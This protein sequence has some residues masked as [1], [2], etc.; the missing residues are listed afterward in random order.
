[1]NAASAIFWQFC[2]GNFGGRTAARA[3]FGEINPSGRLSISI[4][5]HV[6]TQPCYYYRFRSGHG[7]YSDFS[8]P[9]L[10]PFGFGL[11][12]SEI[13]Y[14]S[15]SLNKKEFKIGEK[16]HVSVTIENVGKYDATEV[17]QI[18]IAD[19]LTSV[20]WVDHLLKGFKRQPIKAGERMVVDVV[21]DTNDCWLINA[22]EQRVVEPGA[23]E[24]HV[25]KA[26]NNIQFK[27]GFSIIE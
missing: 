8:A 12:Y 13:K 20:T 19:L 25:A 21:V 26:S 17:I 4:P 11:G 22:D 9:T 1:M 16:I 2:P 5:R 18:Y 7:R 6:G 10:W 27:L 14:I 15:A 3:V 23:F 24:A